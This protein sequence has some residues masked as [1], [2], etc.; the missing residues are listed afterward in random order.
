[1]SAD[2][3]DLDPH[4]NLSE[5]IADTDPQDPGSHLTCDIILAPAPDTPAIRFHTSANRRYAVEYRDSFT[6]GTW[7]VLQ[8][9]STGT[10]TSMVVPDLSA[11]L[12]RIYRVPVSLP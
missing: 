2:N 11:P 7:M 4:D 10:G 6:L 12:H 8:P 1:M 3:P 5:Y 9:A